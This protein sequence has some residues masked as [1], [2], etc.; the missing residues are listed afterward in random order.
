MVAAARQTHY[1]EL[2]DRYSSF[3]KLIR[4]TT[5]CRRFISCLRKIPQSSPLEHP[6]TP[7]ELEQS[8]KFWIRIVQKAWFSYEMVVISRKE[9]LPK[10]HSLVRLT[11]FLDQEGL[12]RVG[13]RL[14]NAQIDSESKHP[15][16]LPRRSPLSKLIIDDAHKRM[17]HGGTQVT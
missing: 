13:G 1:W 3:A 4:V 9:Q 12:L 11:P 16:I 15:F 5:L 6:L 10:S 17:L 14:H 8:R 2:L 7:M